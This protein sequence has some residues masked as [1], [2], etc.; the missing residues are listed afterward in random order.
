M[1]NDLREQESEAQSAIDEVYKQ[2]EKQCKPLESGNGLLTLVDRRTNARYCEC[3]IKAS[4]LSSL[5]TVDVPLDPDSQAQYRA[6]REILTDDP[7]FR[8]M[9]DDAKKG[10]YPKSV[11]DV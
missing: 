7:G 6:N 2:F 1:A 4:V 8:R 5:A 10:S 3:H 11:I 9:Q